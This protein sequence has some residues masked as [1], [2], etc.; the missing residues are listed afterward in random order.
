MTDWTHHVLT[1]VYNYDGVTVALK[2]SPGL[3][4]SSDS[5]VAASLTRLKEILS[6]KASYFYGP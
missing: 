3:N 1:G 5:R 6:K 2:R 4:V